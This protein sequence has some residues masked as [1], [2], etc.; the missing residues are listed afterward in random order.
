MAGHRRHG[1]PRSS[2]GGRQSPKK[3]GP[4]AQALGRS[5]GGFG[6]KIHAVVDALGLPVRFALGPGQQNDMAPACDLLCGLLAL[7]I[8]GDRA[9]DADRFF[10][11]IRAQ[12]GGRSSRRAGTESTSMTMTASPTNSDGASRASSP[13][14]SNGGASPHATTS[15][16]ASCSG[17]NS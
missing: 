13:S 17:S 14:S 4:Q 5:C 16:P 10:D 11:F 2:A 3:G 8:L 12:G 6:T 7:L 15:S 1:G 9:Y